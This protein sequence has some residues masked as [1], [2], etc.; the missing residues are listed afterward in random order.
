MIKPE[1]VI[2]KT[3]LPIQENALVFFLKKEKK[4]IKLTLPTGLTLKLEINDKT[5]R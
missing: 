2:F 3:V 5:F 1:G 4:D